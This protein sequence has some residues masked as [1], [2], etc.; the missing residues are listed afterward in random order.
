MIVEREVKLRKKTN[1][2]SRPSTL[3]LVLCS[4]TLM[5][6]NRKLRQYMQDVTIM[7][8]ER[9]EL[10]VKNKCDNK[11]KSLPHSD[12]KIIGTFFVV[13][14]VTILMLLLLYLKSRFCLDC[15]PIIT[16]VIRLN[17]ILKKIK[18]KTLIFIWNFFSY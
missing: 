7:F 14:V 1:K 16:C 17:R 5:K 2:N 12:Y 4:I 15:L 10:N 9:K 13:V 8:M 6:K 11:I 18:T 3:H